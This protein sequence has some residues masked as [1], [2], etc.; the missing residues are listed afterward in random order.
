MDDLIQ[1]KHTGQRGHDNECFDC[2]KR[3]VP[4]ANVT[5]GGTHRHD[6][7]CCRAKWLCSN[8]CTSK[9]GTVPIYRVCSACYTEEDTSSKELELKLE[10]D[11]F[12]EFVG[13]IRDLLRWIDV[14]NKLELGS[15]VLRSNVE[16]VIE[17]RGC[18]CSCFWYGGEQEHNDDCDGDCY[19]C[20]G[21]EIGSVL[22]MHHEAED[23]LQREG[24]LLLAKGA[25]L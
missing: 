18:D 4:T 24:E 6:C 11:R 12:A 19:P 14:A 9:S 22:D 3:V 13:A 7:P 2:G 20:A 15:V 23:K 10:F 16:Q 25:K 8:G 1:C 21:H 17:R 5:S